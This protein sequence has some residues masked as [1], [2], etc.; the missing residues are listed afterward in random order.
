VLEVIEALGYVPDGAAQSLAQRRKE[1]IGLVAVESRGPET[2]VEREGFL[3]I[4]E[5]LR[6]IERSLGDLGW[7]V[8]ISFLRAADPAGVYQ[9][10]QKISAK[11]DGM[12]IAEGR[13][14][15]SRA[16]RQDEAVLYR[17]PGGSPGCAGAAQRVRGGGGRAPGR[18]RGRMFRGPVRCHQRPAGS[19]R[20]PDPAATGAAGRDH[21]RQ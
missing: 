3:F 2:D 10:M 13:L 11:V 17:G 4:E 5:V 7:S 6:G 21:L 18:D 15:C 12:V 1:V 19:T 9:R 16:A 14:P 8:L 20:D